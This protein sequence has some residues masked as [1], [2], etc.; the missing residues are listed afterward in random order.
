MPKVIEDAKAAIEAAKTPE[1]VDEILA[2]AREAL[3][4][5][6]CRARTSPTWRKTAGITPA[7][8]SW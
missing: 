7:S 8:T 5:A 4:T 1:E 2:A 3:K 6:G